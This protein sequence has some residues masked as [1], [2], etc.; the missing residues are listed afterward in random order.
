MDENP[1]INPSGTPVVNTPPTVEINN[2]V[3]SASQ[4]E[5]ITIGEP[6]KK[7]GGTALLIA[8]LI[9]LALGGIGFGAWATVD[10]GGKV[11][12]LNEQVT[13]LKKQ[14]TELQAK[15]DSGASGSS[16]DGGSSSSSGSS[17]TVNA[18]DYI[19]VGGWETKIKVPSNLL[20]VNYE[21]SL[22]TFDQGTIYYKALCVGGTKDNGAQDGLP[23][24]S[25]KQRVCVIRD[26]G[27]RYS[28]S[29]PW[30]QDPKQATFSKDGLYYWVYGP[31]AIL[32]EQYKDWEVGT[33]ETIKEMLS[34]PDNYSK[35]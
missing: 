24:F 20:N 21:F 18:G 29:G 22:V 30:M 7:S 26:D 8:L 16:T 2:N 6:K 5:P 28:E 14:N 25:T 35:I 23:A 3:P 32:E 17:S 33:V 4:G 12:T 31:Q 1:N 15:V 34:N 10:N 19:Y 9:I 13:T 11:K 27:S